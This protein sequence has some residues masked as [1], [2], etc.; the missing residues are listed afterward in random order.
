MNPRP[1]DVEKLRG[2]EDH[3]RIRIRIGP[4]RVAYRIQDYKLIVEV[5]R[6]GPRKDIYR[7]L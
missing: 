3:Y 4:Y 7:K 1:A 6:I 5:I 2:L